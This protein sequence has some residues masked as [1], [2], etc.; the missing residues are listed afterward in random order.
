[1]D[2]Y[3][4]VWAAINGSMDMFGVPL[5]GP[6]TPACCHQLDHGHVWDTIDEPRVV[7]DGTVYSYG[8]AC[9]YDTPKF[10]FDPQDTY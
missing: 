7:I 1:M 6:W 4:H 10:L 9:I 3:G 5:M 2:I 8:H